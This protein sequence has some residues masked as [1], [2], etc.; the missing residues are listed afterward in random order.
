MLHAGLAA[1]LAGTVA[2]ACGGPGDTAREPRGQ[3]LRRRAAKDTASLIAAYDAT[4]KAHPGLAGELRPLRAEL[5]RHLDA[6]GGHEPPTAPSTAPSSGLPDAGSPAG[7]PATGVPESPGAARRLL[8]EAEHRT[9]RSRTDD[10]LAAPPELARLLASV[11]ASGA[12][13]VLLLR[14]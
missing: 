14:S 11:A 12:G 3:E 2:V 8:A 10:L 7:A 1:G 4:A 5:E 9:S 13:H 6:F